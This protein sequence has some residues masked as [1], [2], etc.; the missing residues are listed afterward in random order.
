MNS[1]ESNFVP[2]QIALDMKS[3][4]F[5]EP[6]WCYFMGDVFNS[7]M[8]L[9][10][11]EYLDTMPQKYT[12]YTLAPL[13]QQAFRWFREKHLLHSH[14]TCSCTVNEILSYDWVIHKL[15]SSGTREEN[16]LTDYEQTYEEAEL[17]CLKKLIEIVKE[18]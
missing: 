9:K 13:Y 11:Y 17:E 1:I 12:T 7:S 18:R 15:M 3:I 14:I 2:Y 5:D 6:C 10:D 16:F 4:G 8:F